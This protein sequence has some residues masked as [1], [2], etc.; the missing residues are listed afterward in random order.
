MSIRD[1]SVRVNDGNRQYER[2]FGS[3][4]AARD[5]AVRMN[6]T[7]IFRNI[8]VN[9]SWSILMLIAP[10]AQQQGE[11][12]EQVFA[13]MT[14]EIPTV[15]KIKNILKYAVSKEECTKAFKAV[16]ATP[17]ADQLNNI[18]IVT[19]SVF[20]DSKY[21]EFWTRGSKVGEGMR[22]GLGAHP[23]TN[24]LGYPGEYPGT[25]RRF[26]GL[27]NRAVKETD[28]WLPVTI[29]HSFIHSGGIRGGQTW[30]EWATWRRS[31]RTWGEWWEQKHPHDLRFLG[32]EY[33]DIIK[34]CLNNVESK[35][36][37]AER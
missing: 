27:T 29:I 31:N 37:K 24:D 11:V 21:D 30:G 4:G 15:N 25:G 14:N 6:Q 2:S 35:I 18:T 28:D 34:H 23:K 3:E 8:L 12:N 1:Y 13:H 10:Q 17:I 36:G 9:D 26:I 7:T 20:N 22:A 33:D 32:K 16:G 5:F 19:E